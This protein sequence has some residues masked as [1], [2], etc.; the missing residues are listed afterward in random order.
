MRSCIIYHSYTG[1]TRSI[2]EIIQASCGG[3]LIEVKPR[4]KYT[5]L[6]AY[7]AGCLRARNEE[8]D[9]VDPEIIDVSSCDLLVIG[10]PVWV[11]KP[12]PA[13]NAGIAA[14]KGCEG[15]QAIIFATCGGQ[16]GETL[17]IM[18]SALEAKGVKVVREFTFTKREIKEPDKI[19]NVVNAVKNAGNGD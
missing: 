7:T 11:W 17:S 1:I 14:L 3:D 6:T 5:T 4:Q 19:S 2:A 13:T 12:T 8:R 15:K 16:P 10:T 9:P 18:K